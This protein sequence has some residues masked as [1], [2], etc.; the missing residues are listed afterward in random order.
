MP[1]N[2]GAYSS[3]TMSADT[4]GNWVRLDHLIELLKT[5]LSYCTCKDCKWV[6]EFYGV[7]HCDNIESSAKKVCLSFGCIHWEGK[8][9][10]KTTKAKDCNA[11]SGMDNGDEAVC[12]KCDG[13]GKIYYR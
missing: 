11:C 8:D 3:D 13:V 2:P 9:D 10:Q 1:H 7:H 4:T 5:E 6:T 12:D